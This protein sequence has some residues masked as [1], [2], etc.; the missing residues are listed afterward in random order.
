M[1]DQHAERAG[2]MHGANRCGRQS[3]Q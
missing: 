3:E 1:L 2:R